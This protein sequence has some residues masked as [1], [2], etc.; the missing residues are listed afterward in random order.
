MTNKYVFLFVILAL[1]ISVWTVSAGDSRIDKIKVDGETY[2]S[3]RSE[4][5][6][7]FTEQQFELRA[8]TKDC[9]DGYYLEYKIPKDSEERI[10]IISQT[11]DGAYYVANFKV[12]DATGNA[13]VFLELKDSDGQHKGQSSVIFDIEVPYIVEN[14]TFDIDSSQ[15]D[16]KKVDI[17]IDNGLTSEQEKNLDGE[18]DVTISGGEKPRHFSSKDFSVDLPGG[19]SYHVVAIFKDKLGRSYQGEE[20]FLVENLKFNYRGEEKIEIIS[21]PTVSRVGE[22]WSAKLKIHSDGDC[23][24]YVLDGQKVIRR[25]TYNASEDSNTFT[26][27]YAFNE[28]GTHDISIVA[29][30][31]TEDKPLATATIQVVVGDSV[32]QSGVQQNSG[33]SYNDYSGTSH[34]EVNWPYEKMQAEEQLKKIEAQN[35]K[36]PGFGFFVTVITLVFVSIFLKKKE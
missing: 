30:K 8:K 10:E 27:N 36:S 16:K 14:P 1:M 28:T 31:F 9:P 4:A 5:V 21:A 24:I 23:N 11:R 18:W 2:Y 12:L 29:R 15:G 19:Y 17:S 34:E 33:Q 7:V 3:E 25:I 26:I 13:E 6:V 32:I 35:K 20:D 22:E